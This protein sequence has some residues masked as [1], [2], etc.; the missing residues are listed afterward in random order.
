MAD[1]LAALANISINYWKKWT[2]VKKIE[3]MENV[4]SEFVEQQIP[5][6]EK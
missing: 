6:E 2:K 3:Q 4:C 1:S 5:K